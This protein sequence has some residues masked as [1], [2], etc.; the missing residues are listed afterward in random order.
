MSRG[1]LFSIAEESLLIFVEKEAFIIIPSFSV[2]R[3][4]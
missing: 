4:S 3:E 2:K 1:K